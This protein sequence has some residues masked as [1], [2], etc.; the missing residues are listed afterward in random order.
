M[1]LSDA[2]AAVR[3]HLARHRIAAAWDDREK[4]QRAIDDVDIRVSLVYLG[5]DPQ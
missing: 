5:F 3:G 4:Q 2:V 1:P